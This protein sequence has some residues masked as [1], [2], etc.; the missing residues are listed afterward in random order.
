MTPNFYFISETNKSLSVRS[1]SL[2][3]IYR[4]EIFARTS[5][6]VVATPYY[7][8]SPLKC[9]QTKL[10]KELKVVVFQLPAVDKINEKLLSEKITEYMEP[11]VSHYRSVYRKNNGC[12]CTILRLA[13]N[14]KSDLDDKKVVEVL[15]S[16]MGKAFDSLCPPLLIKKLDS[17]HFSGSVVF[18]LAKK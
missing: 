12:E 8:T 11:K 3:K 10:N 4:V 9:S 14:W 16:D 18:F 15:S 17:Y 13:E 6:T 5:L 1:R 7:T 2:K